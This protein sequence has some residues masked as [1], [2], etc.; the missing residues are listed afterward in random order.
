MLCWPVDTAEPLSPVLPWDSGGLLW[1][2]HPLRPLTIQP[3][4]AAPSCYDVSANCRSFRLG[5]NVWYDSLALKEGNRP[6][7]LAGYPAPELLVLF[8]LPLCLHLRA[9]LLVMFPHGCNRVPCS[10]TCCP[11]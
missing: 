7:A 5:S 6:S 10:Q 2:S 9:V 1:C 4:L 8:M 11:H 3:S